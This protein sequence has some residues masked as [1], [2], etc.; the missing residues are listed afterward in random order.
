MLDG[1]NP[2]QKFWTDSNSLQMIERNLYKR[3]DP[4]FIIEDKYSNIS[5]NYY[6]VDSAIAMRD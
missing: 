6:P 3:V 5:G 4:R 1:F 2:K